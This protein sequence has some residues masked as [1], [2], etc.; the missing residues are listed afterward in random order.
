MRV[1][2]IFFLWFYFSLATVNMHCLDKTE[3]VVFIYS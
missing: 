1:I 3:T 2:L